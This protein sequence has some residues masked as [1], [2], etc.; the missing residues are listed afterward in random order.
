MSKL[1]FLVI[2]ILALT[3]AGC[4]GG[5]DDDSMR[6]TPVIEMERPAPDPMPEPEPAIV[7]PPQKP[8]TLPALPLLQP[9]DAMQAPIIRRLTTQGDSTHVGATLGVASTAPVTHHGEI[10]V[11]YNGTLRGISVQDLLTY[12]AADAEPFGRIKQ[13]DAPPT[14]YLASPEGEPTPQMIDDAVF[15]VQIINSFLPDDWQ[16]RFGS[17][18]NPSP[19]NSMTVFFQDAGLSERG[20]GGHTLQTYDATLK[21]VGAN[22]YVLPDYWTNPS[23]FRD[24]QEKIYILVH[25]IL[26]ALGRGHV[27]IDRSRVSG[28]TI[29]DPGVPGNSGFALFPVDREA[30]HAI[31]SELDPGDSLDTV[32]EKLG[33]WNDT[34]VMMR[35]DFDI[36]EGGGSFG[37]SMRFGLGRPWASGPTPWTL[38][39][40]NPALSGSAAWEGRLLGFTPEA[41]PVAGSA[42]LGIDLSTLSGDLDFQGLESWAAGT[43][44]GAI[45]TGQQWGDGSLSY[46]IQLRDNTFVQSGG[47]DGIVTGAFFGPQHEGMG[48]ILE[49]DDLTAAFGG[50]R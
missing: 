40:D 5:G 41:Q 13:W 11:S 9:S 44:P 1:S 43:V 14:I 23:M 26:H 47:D 20:V 33:D 3:L 42:Q 27:P 50:K 35:G 32:A 37:V 46:D 8:D 24:Q 10:P 29:M 4:G 30:L 34:G 49:R 2:P 6:V 15:A 19:G 36:T 31:H 7:H 25:E 45:G 21:M 38:L 39:A 12:L 22:V 28:L 16:L 17:A 18:D 48:G